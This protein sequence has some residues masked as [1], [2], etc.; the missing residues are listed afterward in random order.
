MAGGTSGRVEPTE[1]L[2]PASGPQ[3]LLCGTSRASAALC[4][5]PP[6]ASRSV[7]Q[8]GP[9]LGREDRVVARGGPDSRLLSGARV[10]SQPCVLRR[11]AV[12]RSCLYNGDSGKCRGCWLYPSPRVKRLQVYFQAPGKRNVSGDGLLLKAGGIYFT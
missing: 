8:S 3:L 10:L 2:A 1:T 11:A 5:V 9:G 6:L 12:Y 7:P 4:K